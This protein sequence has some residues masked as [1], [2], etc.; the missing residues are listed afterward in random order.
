MLVL[1][2][3]EDCGPSAR[4]QG[5][6][7]LQGSAARDVRFT[8]NAACLSARG[9]IRIAPRIRKTELDWCKWRLGILM[10]NGTL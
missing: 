9:K 6:A 8:S 5:C 1:R 10:P 3:K 2:P 7:M 4:H